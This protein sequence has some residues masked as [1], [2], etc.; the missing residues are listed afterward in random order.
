MAV[1]LS[2]LRAGRPFVG[3]TNGRKLKGQVEWSLVACIHTKSHVNLLTAR[4]S[5]RGSHTIAH[6]KYDNKNVN[7]NV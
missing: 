3:I 1:R 6:E 2:A 4:N 7:A 5:F